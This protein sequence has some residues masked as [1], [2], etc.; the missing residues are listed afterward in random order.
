MSVTKSSITQS[1]DDL[2]R[3]SSIHKLVE[4][5]LDAHVSDIKLYTTGHLN[6]NRYV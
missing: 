1:Q 5:S 2:K 4:R 3:P 6:F